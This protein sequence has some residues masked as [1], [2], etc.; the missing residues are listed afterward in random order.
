[1]SKPVGE[2][3]IEPEP[4]PYRDALFDAHDRLNIYPPYPTVINQTGEFEV[5]LFDDYENVEI[6]ALLSG[7]LAKKYAELSDEGKYEL[8]DYIKQA[9]GRSAVE[10]SDRYSTLMHEEDTV[11]LINDVPVMFEPIHNAMLVGEWDDWEKK[12]MNIRSRFIEN[13]DQQRL[14]LGGLAAFVTYLEQQ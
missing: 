3:S 2:L 5:Y 8:A 10:V 4:S 14:L 1:M 11:V 12:K 13:R 9:I 6:E 7:K